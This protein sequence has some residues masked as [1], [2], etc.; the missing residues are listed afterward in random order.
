METV[1]LVFDQALTRAVGSIAVPDYP[2]AKIASRVTRRSATMSAMLS[3]RL[4]AAF[5][6]LMCCAGLA[7]AAPKILDSLRFVTM[8]NGEFR[9]QTQNTDITLNRDRALRSMLADKSFHVVLP[10]GWPGDM[11]QGMIVRVGPPATYL[12]G[13]HSTGRDSK[14]GALVFLQ[15]KTITT[16]KARDRMFGMAA[17]RGTNWTVSSWAVGSEQ[18][19]MFANSLNQDELRRIRQSTHY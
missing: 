6:A 8:K 3:R 9:I 10:T 17:S 5:V 14:R 18:I 15:S 1:N 16:K 2:S 7:Y 19:T 11:R 4:A 12:V 13:Y